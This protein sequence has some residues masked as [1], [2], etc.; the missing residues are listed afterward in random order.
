MDK[1]QA[2]HSFWSGFG[3]TAIDEQS[4]Y[5][6]STIEDLG[7]TDK[8]ITYEVG[9]G[10]IGD[11]IALSASLWHRSTSWETISKKA[12]EIAAYIGYSGRVL[13]VDG[14]YLWVKLGSP[15]ARRMPVDA[16]YDMR[17]IYLN[18]SADFLTAT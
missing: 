2:L 17:R 1:A 8:Y 6:E 11:P 5:D 7:V 14:G 3:W 12:D 15:F 9:T 13:P 18:I 4:A 16:D 10:N